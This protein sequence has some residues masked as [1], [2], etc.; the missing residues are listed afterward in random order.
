[1]GHGD[2]IALC[3]ERLRDRQA[4]APIAAGHQYRARHLRPLRSPTA[5]QL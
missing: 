3:G 5:R 4:D 1:M 2:P